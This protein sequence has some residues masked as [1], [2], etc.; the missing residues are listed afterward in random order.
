MVC[1]GSWSRRGGGRITVTHGAGRGGAHRADHLSSS[2]AASTIIAASSSSNLSIRAVD[3]GRPT[4]SHTIWRNRQQQ[5]KL[6]VGGLYVA[7]VGDLDPVGIRR[8]THQRT[9]APRTAGKPG[10]CSSKRK[11]ASSQL[12]VATPSEW[13]TI[14]GTNSNQ[15]AGNSRWIKDG[16]K[17]VAIA[18]TGSSVVITDKDLSGNL[19]YWWQQADTAQWHREIVATGAFGDPAMAWTGSS[20]VIAA[21]DTSDHLCYWWQQADTAQWHREIVATSPGGFGPPVLAWTGCSV[22][23]AAEDASGNIRYWWQQGDTAPW[24]REIVANVG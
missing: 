20:V 17:M 3:G 1:L 13:L 15:A 8:A 7:H 22:V 14:L 23:L 6:G 11:K 5:P 21:T 18:W 24:H 19:R 9:G 10:G 16:R 4:S 2:S 12:L